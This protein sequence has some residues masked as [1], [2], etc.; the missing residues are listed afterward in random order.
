MN[1]TLG[2]IGLLACSLGIGLFV[3]DL[4]LGVH[5][6]TP[7]DVKAR[8]AYAR[9][10]AL[11]LDER[12]LEVVAESLRRSGQP[13]MFRVMPFEYRRRLQG[14]LPLGGVSHTLQVLCNATGQ[15]LVVP[16][17]QH[18]FL[19]PDSAWNQ[20]QLALLGD[21]FAAGFCVP[22]ESSFA[23]LL[24]VNRSVIN[25]GM[26]GN[27]PLMELAT[28]REYLP[29]L[30]PPL[31]VWAYYAANDFGDLES[32]S[33]DPRL[34]GY[35]NHGY[36]Q[37]L[38]N[39]QPLI[40]S[41]LISYEKQRRATAPKRSETLAELLRGALSLKHL[42]EAIVPPRS[43][44]SC[45][46]LDLLS[47]VLLEARMVVQSWDGKLL[48]VYLPSRHALAEVPNK[49]EAAHDSVLALARSAGLAILDLTSVLTPSDYPFMGAHF[50]TEGNLK[51][52]R[53][54]EG[55]VSLN[56]TRAR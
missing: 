47:R 10:H 28:L 38:V 3:A 17:D 36:L 19:N 6:L 52:A 18:G 40:D 51:V 23:G 30:R 35:L 54:I 16:T 39:L 29:A 5:P 27:G 25:L 26:A 33:S 41:T 31:V 32:E 45:C 37:G 9:N 22:A 8:R 55:W 11:P 2:K 46:A 4:A 53:A 12:P 24:R 20:P 21:S 42:R 48:F 34:A 43:R 49:R 7:H 15:A 13:A 56:A 1:E 50:T 44:D 14:M